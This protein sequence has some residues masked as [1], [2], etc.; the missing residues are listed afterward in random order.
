ML[1]YMIYAPL[2]FTY[3]ICSTY[4]QR[5]LGQ[6]R[7]A[8]GGRVAE[9]LLSGPLNITTGNL[10]FRFLTYCLLPSFLYKLISFILT[11]PLSF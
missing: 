6:L 2:G 1:F 3:Y 10:S 8:L 9:E 4:Q 11:L 5:F 7:S